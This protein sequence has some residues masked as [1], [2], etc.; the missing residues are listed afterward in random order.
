MQHDKVNDVL[1][2]AA[3]GEEVALARTI[4]G[5]EVRFD[6]PDFDQAVQMYKDGTGSAEMLCIAKGRYKSIWNREKL[7]KVLSLADFDIVG[8]I[9]GQN[10]STNDGWLRVIARRC[11]RPQPSLPMTDVQ[12][13]M[14]MPRIAW[15]DTMGALHLSCARLGI[16]FIK[17]VGVCWG[18]VLER[19][20]EQCLEKKYVLTVDYDSIFEEHDIIRLWQIM[21]SNPD[22]DAL[23]PLQIGRDRDSVLLT[24]LDGS[25]SRMRYVDASEFRREVIP[26]ETGH[27]G[28]TLIRTD[29]LRKMSKPWFLSVPNENGEWNGDKIDDDIYFWKKFRQTGLQCCVS[30]RVRIGHLQLIS[31]WPGEDLRTIHQYMTQYSAEGRPQECMTY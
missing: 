15:T 9:D 22:V 19:M 13:I 24:M 25:G 7:A 11:K 27:F 6:V 23:F 2:T 5:D 26:C 28:L 3:S 14:S 4:T 21:E 16:N 1:A 29:A 12:A 17:G 31:T 30:P 18:Q 20:M 10:W 8:G